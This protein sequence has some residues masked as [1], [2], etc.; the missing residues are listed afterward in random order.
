MYH[1][2]YFQIS[3][4]HA[5]RSKSPLLAVAILIVVRWDKSSL[6]VLPLWPYNPHADSVSSSPYHP[7]C[8]TTWELFFPFCRADARTPRYWS[9]SKATN[10]RE[11]GYPT[12]PPFATSCHQNYSH[13]AAM[14]SPKIIFCLFWRRR[15][16]SLMLIPFRRSLRVDISQYIS[17]LEASWNRRCS[18]NLAVV[19]ILAARA[20]KS[21]C[22]R[23]RLLLAFCS[24]VGVEAIFLLHC[25]TSRLLL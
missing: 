15:R 19:V 25:L 12:S 13:Y 14:L 20:Q 11:R 23:W 5:V 6:L 10:E 22:C 4:L 3:F 21:S 17:R 8:Y 18:S 2:F 24:V 16:S 7:S 9:P 1:A